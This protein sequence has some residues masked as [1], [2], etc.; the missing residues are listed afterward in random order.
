MFL[1]FTISL[2]FVF[3]GVSL[4]EAEPIAIGAMVFFFYY[5]ILKYRQSGISSIN[6]AILYSIIKGIGAL[7]N[8]VAILSSDDPKSRDIYFLYVAEEHINLAMLLHFFGPV[9]TI[10]GFELSQNKKINLPNLKYILNDYHLSF[11][12]PLLVFLLFILKYFNLIPSLGTLSAFIQLIPIA[13]IFFLARYGAYTNQNKYVRIAFIFLVL[14]TAQAL[15]YAFLRM[16]IVLPSVA[17]VLGMLIGKRSFSVLK[18]PFFYPVYFGLFL[19]FTY[20]TLIGEKRGQIGVGFERIERLQEAAE[21]F[22]D[23]ERESTLLSR[24]SSINQL[25]QIGRIVEEDDFYYGETLDYLVFGFI[26]R[27]LWPE[28]PIIQKGAWFAYRI[29]KARILDGKYTN[30]IDMSSTGELY[31]NF[32]WL[33][34]LI[35][36]LFIG[37]FIGSMWLTSGF[38]T[39]EKNVLGSLFGFYLLFLGLFSFGA[40]LQMILTLTAMYLVFWGTNKIIGKGSA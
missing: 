5:P 25:S 32:G 24:F 14:T 16:N 20:F 37:Y 4:E 40:D 12:F 39:G 28:K 11:T 15:F 36:G 33:G 29:G 27:F 31:L 9:L 13:S 1:L 26:P 30:S 23:E 7:G 17:F 19:F 2:I 22:E 18:T 8:L 38:W 34:V 21:E 3:Y 10:F 6:P 35:G